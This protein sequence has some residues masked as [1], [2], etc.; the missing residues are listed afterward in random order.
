MRRALAFA[1]SLLFAAPAFAQFKDADVRPFV[2]VADER[3][4]ASTTFNAVFGSTTSA[5]WGGGVDVVVRRRYF[6]DFAVSHMSKSGQ[7][8]FMNNGEVFRLGIPLEASL[9]PLELTAGY[10]FRLKTPRVV[11]Y[12]GA[13]VGSYGYHETADFA[14]A[15]DDVDTRHA[16]LVLIGGAEVRISKWI[17]VTGD[18][19]Y[20]HVPGILGQGGLSKDAGEDNLGGVA[21][22]LRV[23]LG[24]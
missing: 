13:G 8:A 10:R 21:A 17:G 3:F 15:G 16:G 6:I 20:T 7:R 19:Q 1:V 11:P 14:A 5:L 4:A 18:A 22:R 23:I 9:T 12:V 2:L 24:R